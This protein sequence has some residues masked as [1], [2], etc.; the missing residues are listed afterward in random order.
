MN[1]ILDVDYN[2]ENPVELNEDV[3]EYG[4]VFFS[5]LANAS[6]FRMVELLMA[7]E[8]TVGDIA[9]A[10]SISQPSASHHLAILG[11]AGVLTVTP[12]GVARYYRLRGPRIA[13][14]VMLLAEFRQIHREA[15]AA[16]DVALVGAQGRQTS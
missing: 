14:I 12:K 7:G 10:L 6:R 1:R 5:S 16:D 11:R 15:M 4:V 13:M 3:V 8:K 2:R 9:S